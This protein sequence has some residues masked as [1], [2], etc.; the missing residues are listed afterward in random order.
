MELIEW[1]YAYITDLVEFANDKEIAK[2]LRDN[3]PHPYREQNA[4]DFVSF[5]LATSDVKQLSYAIFYQERAIGSISLTFEE[6]TSINKN[7]EL[8]YWL[9]RNY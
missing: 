6:D 9:A 2:N 4:R 8:G 3:F 7:A 1:N 5:C